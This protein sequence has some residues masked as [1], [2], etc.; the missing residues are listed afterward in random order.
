MPPKEGKGKIVEDLARGFLDFIIHAYH[1]AQ[2]LVSYFNLQLI[3]RFILNFFVF[4]ILL[5]GSISLAGVIYRR[6]KPQSTQELI[7]YV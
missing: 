6:Y 1:G 2:N 5:S 7:M 3:S 4:M